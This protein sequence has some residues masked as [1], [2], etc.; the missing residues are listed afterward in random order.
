MGFFKTDVLHRD[1]IVGCESIDGEWSPAKVRIYNKLE[2]V[3][4]C[5]CMCVSVCVCVCVWVCGCVVDY[6]MSACIYLRCFSDGCL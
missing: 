5:V 2:F 1:E 4:V 6:E 3:C